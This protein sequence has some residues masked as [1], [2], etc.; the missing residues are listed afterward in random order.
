MGA[1]SKREPLSTYGAELNVDGNSEINSIQRLISLVS[2]LRAGSHL[3]TNPVAIILG[4]HDRSEPV[5]Q[6]KVPFH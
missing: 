4:L 6:R 1:C 2:D 5:V 3:V